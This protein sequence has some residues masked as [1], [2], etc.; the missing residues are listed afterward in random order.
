MR[1]KKFHVNFNR[2]EHTHKEVFKGFSLGIDGLAADWIT[3]NIFW[4]DT[5]LQQIVAS[6]NDFDEYVMLSSL[7]NVA[8][9]KITVHPFQG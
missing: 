9:G 3:G 1:C 2:Q 6:D 8:A 7:D 5:K 4:V